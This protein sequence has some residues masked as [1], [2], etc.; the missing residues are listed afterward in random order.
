MCNP[1]LAVT[2]AS[3]LFS[4]YSGYEQSS[5]QK[6][7]AKAN[8]VE[9]DRAAT[10]TITRGEKEA[11]SAMRQNRMLKGAQ[12][13]SLAARGLDLQDGGTAQE[14]QDQTD[15]FGQVDQNTIKDN[16]AKEARGLKQRGAGFRNQA[17]AESPVG[18]TVGSLLGSTGVVADKWQKYNGGG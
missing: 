12:R 17:A 3:G 10:D 5:A 4:A 13:N 9:A 6:A 14:L 7:A 18:N 11:Q 1:V 8:A 2:V 15:F 16:A